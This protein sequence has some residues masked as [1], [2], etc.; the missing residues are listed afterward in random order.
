MR[1]RFPVPDHDHRA[2]AD[3]NLARARATYA[4][5]GGRLTRLRETV[6]NELAQSHRALGAYDIMRRI[7]RGGRS[8]A[9]ISVYRALESLAD[10]GL[11]HRLES[12]NAYVACYGGHDQERPVLFLLC[13]RCGTVAESNAPAMVEALRTAAA[14]ARFALS[15]SVLEA[16]GLCAHCAGNG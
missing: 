13:E 4:R 2:C 8:I 5:R 6:L 10:A 7:E 16:R 15:Q 1:T 12:C 9:P 3:E 11:V 14:Q